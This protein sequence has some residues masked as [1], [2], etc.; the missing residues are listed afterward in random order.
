M[1]EEDLSH[2]GPELLPDLWC[3]P[4]GGSDER[5]RRERVDLALARPLAFG[6]RL[7]FWP[8]SFPRRSSDR[9]D[10]YRLPLLR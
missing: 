3:P 5:A 8:A 9:R 6:C 7:G 10:G 2:L 1:A 4:Y